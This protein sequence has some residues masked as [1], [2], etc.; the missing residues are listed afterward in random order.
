MEI[1]LSIRLIDI[2]YVWSSATSQQQKLLL[3]SSPLVE[4]LV[5]SLTWL[6]KFTKT[7][8]EHDTEQ[9]H[10]PLPDDKYFDLLHKLFIE[11]ST[12]FVEKSRTVMATWWGSGECLHYVMT[13]Q[14]ASCIFWCPDQARAE[15][16]IKYCKVFYEQQDQALK[17]LY[18]LPR[19]KKQIDDQ[20]VYRFEFGGGWL[21]ALPGKN[22]DRI[23]SEHPTIVFMDE[24][25]FNEHG[26][27]AYGNAVSTRPVKLVAISS[28][29]PGWFYDMIDPAEPIDIAGTGKGLSVRKIPETKPAAGTKVVRLDYSADPTMTPKRVAE[30]KPKR[31]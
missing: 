23:R 8:D 27:E 3:S 11:E 26:L 2:P 7:W 14:P 9:P 1:P 30:E 5:S 6:R 16:C 12:L 31:R 4:P 17:D 10:K 21:E 28:A 13:H 15:K 25:A 22:P 29:Y 18:P 20:A 19:K 24:A